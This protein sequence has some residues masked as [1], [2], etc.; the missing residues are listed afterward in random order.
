MTMALKTEWIMCSDNTDID[1]QVAALERYC[2]GKVRVLKCD[3]ESESESPMRMST[4]L[5]FEVFEGTN[6]DE[7]WEL[8]D[9]VI[10]GEREE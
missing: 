1:G 7:F 2:V 4:K 10:G 8:V 9:D 3:S 6:M 5:E